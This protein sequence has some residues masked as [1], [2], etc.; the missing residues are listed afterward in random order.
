MCCISAARGSKYASSKR[1]AMSGPLGALLCAGGASECRA[2]GRR[3]DMASCLARYHCGHVTAS[4]VMLGTRQH[5]Y[6]PV[7]A[8]DDF[9]RPLEREVE[10][11]TDEMRGDAEAGERRLG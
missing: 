7:L 4:V 9:G 11:F 2:S 6:R 10:H 5:V 1:S 3:S 8:L